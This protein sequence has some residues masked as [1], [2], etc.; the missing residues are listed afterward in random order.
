MLEI[1]RLQDAGEIADDWEIQDEKVQ[2]KQSKL[3]AIYGGGTEDEDEDEDED[4]ASEDPA[5]TLDLSGGS[6][7]GGSS[8]RALVDLTVTFFS[9]PYRPARYCQCE[10]RGGSFL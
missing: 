9:R 2:K 5:L 3:N 4:D 1:E 7:G 6:N 8:V 10:L